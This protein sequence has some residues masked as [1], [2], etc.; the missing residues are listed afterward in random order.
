MELMR[1]VYGFH[2]KRR[3]NS[4]WPTETLMLHVWSTIYTTRFT[5]DGEVSLRARYK[6]DLLLPEELEHV[7]TEFVRAFV[8]QQMK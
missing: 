4:M 1:D 7:F 3:T 6:A 8:P 5:I 2:Q